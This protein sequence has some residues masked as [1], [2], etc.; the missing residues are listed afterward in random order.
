MPST[1]WTIPAHGGNARQLT[2]VGEP[3]GGH[4]SPSWSPDGKRIVFGSYDPETTDIWTI[5]AAGTDLKKIAVGVDPIYAPD[6]AHIY[7]ASL[8]RSANLNLGVSKIKVSENGDPQGEPVEIARTGSSRVKRLTITANGDALAYGALT[9]TSNLWS[10]PVSPLTNEAMGPPVAL[11][12][13]TSHRISSPSVSPDGKRI[14]YHVA[15]VGTSADIWMID[16]NGANPTQLTTDPGSDIRPSWFPDGK[17][18]IF[19]SRR[20]GKDKLWTIDLPSGREKPLLDIAQDMTFPQLSPDGKLILFNS[21][22]SGTTN[23][24]IVPTEGGEPKQ[25]TFDKQTM[26]FGCW[27]PDGQFIAFEIK[28]GDDTHLG[29]IPASGGEPVQLTFDRG[30]SWPHSFSPDG[31]KIA[32]A[33][34][35]EGHWNVWWISRSTRTQKKLTNN[36]KLNT[37]VRYP[38]WSPRGYQIVYEYAETTGNIWLLELK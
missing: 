17:Q 13:D 24:W 4:G 18:L 5:S 29:L 35:R 16:A 1:I 30:Q 22:K 28:R 26:G 33:G 6:G 3:A 32:F 21:K 10:A 7:F 20:E 23:L 25:L 38:S 2:K 12:R 11:T 19:L 8:L 14:A 9:T 34:F 37:F 27:S 36:S 31:D 15:R